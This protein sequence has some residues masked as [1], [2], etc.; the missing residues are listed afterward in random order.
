MTAQLQSRG[1]NWDAAKLFPVPEA[2][3]NTVIARRIIDFE[4]AF[5]LKVF[6]CCTAL[7]DEIY[8]KAR[9]TSNEPEED[10]AVQEEHNARR[11]I[12]RGLT[13]CIVHVT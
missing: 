13:E 3:G 6:V 1:R 2:R 4:W 12:S 11:L 7:G 5:E 9:E 8:V 10:E